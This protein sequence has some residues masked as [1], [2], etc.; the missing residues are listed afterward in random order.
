MGGSFAISRGCQLAF[1]SPEVLPPR[2]RRRLRLRFGRSAP[3]SAGGSLSRDAGREESRDSPPRPPRLS[4]ER[5]PRPRSLP[6]PGPRRPAPLPVSPRSST[7]SASR[8]S[9]V[10]CARGRRPLVPSGMSRSLV[11]VRGGGV[12]LLRLGDAEVERLV[13]QRPAGQ[14]V[15]VDERDRDAGL[16]GPA[17]AADAVQVGLLVLGALVVDDVRD[18]ARRRC[19]GRRRRWRRGRRPCR[20]GTRA[21]PARGRPG[22]GRRGWRAAAKPRSVELVGDLGGGALGAAE[23]HGQAAALG[24]QDAGEHLDLV[25][26]VRAVDE[27][28]DRL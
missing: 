12:G 19:R 5:A 7:S 2:V 14:V 28:L 21:A 3:P 25:Q 8:P 23:D 27:L 26:R 15:P 1:V 22:R 16:A 13:D 10:R 17:G 4:P 6:P 20:C 9:R 11:Q 18:V 24:L